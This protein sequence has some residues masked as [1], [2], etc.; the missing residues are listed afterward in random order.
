VLALRS[1]QHCWILILGFLFFLKNR[2]HG[3]H[4]EKH[5]A[6]FK[7]GAADDDAILEDEVLENRRG[8]IE[9]DNIGKGSSVDEKKEELRN[10]TVWVSMWVSPC[11]VFSF[12]VNTLYF[13]HLV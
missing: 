2:N 9:K 5:R 8:S 3:S 11:G 1:H 12:C 10:E 13:S 4:F 6:A 7:E